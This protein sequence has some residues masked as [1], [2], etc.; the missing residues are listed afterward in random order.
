MNRVRLAFALAAALSCAHTAAAQD[1]AFTVNDKGSTRRVALVVGNNAYVEK[2]L[3]NAVRDAKAIDKALR[4]SGFEVTVALDTSL[5]DLEHAIDQFI[6]NVHEGDV[7]MFYYSGHGAQLASENYLLP[8]DFT[9]QEEAQVKYQAIPASMIVDRMGASGARLNIVVLDACRNNPFGS[10]KSGT[11]GLAPMESGRGSLIAF[12]TAPNRTADD[13]RSGANGLFTSYVLE[14]MQIPGLDIE[15]VFSRVRQ[16]VYQDS[17]GAQIPWVVS[18]VIGDFY[19]HGAPSGGGP[20]VPPPLPRPHTID[21]KEAIGE[22]LTQYRLA[23]QAMDV[24]AVVKIFPGFTGR[25]ELQRRFADLQGVAMALGTPTI[26]LTSDTTATASI[27]YSLTFTA[28]SGKIE[29]LRPQN[30]EFKFKK[31]SGEWVIDS[32]RF[33]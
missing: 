18:S 29:Q 15:Q 1:R 17:K 23:Y 12:A 20:V 24:D 26:A 27:L 4:D 11:K 6:A 32:V 10:A 28:K 7:A 9:T 5:K 14:A 22:T 31:T 30:A 3:Q 33:R 16:A 2:P 25:Q 8:V 13:N 21:P 19:F